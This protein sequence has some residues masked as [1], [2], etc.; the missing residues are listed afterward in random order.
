MVAEHAG[1]FCNAYE[2]VTRLHTFDDVIHAFQCHVCIAQQQLAK[3]SVTYNY[4]TYVTDAKQIEVSSHHSN[5]HNCLAM[6]CSCSK[7]CFCYL[8]VLCLATICSCSKSCFCYQFKY[9]KMFSEALYWH[10]QGEFSL[11][12]RFPDVRDNVVLV[13]GLFNESLPPFIKKHYKTRNPVD[14]TYLHIDCDLY[15]G[16]HILL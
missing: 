11:E 14:I 1:S 7:S 15:A 13:Q 2:S 10:M 6:I 12:G 3:P 4:C 5:R 8:F 16:E 9:G